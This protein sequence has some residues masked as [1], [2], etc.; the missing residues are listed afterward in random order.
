MDC[1]KIILNN[2][3][4]IDILLDVDK[5]SLDDIAKRVSESPEL[6]DQ[7]IRELPGFNEAFNEDPPKKKSADSSNLNGA[8]NIDN[9]DVSFLLSNAGFESSLLNDN[10]S[11]NLVEGKRDINDNSLGSIYYNSDDNT[12]S[13]NVNT[14]NIDAIDDKPSVLVNDY[15]QDESILNHIASA[16]LA[17]ANP[18]KKKIIGIY[19]NKNEIKDLGEKVNKLFPKEMKPNKSIKKKVEYILSE[20][21]NNDE[22]KDALTKN[23]DSKYIN[24]VRKASGSSNGFEFHVSTKEKEVKESEPDNINESELSFNP[25]EITDIEKKTAI[26]NKVQ[27]FKEWHK[28]M[29]FDSRRDAEKYITNDSRVLSP[30]S[31]IQKKDGTISEALGSSPVL[32]KGE[33]KVS[34]TKYRVLQ[35]FSDGTNKPIT[36]ADITYK[37]MANKNIT[38]DDYFNN[39]LE[40]NVGI[41]FVNRNNNKLT[42]IVANVSKD[43]V[44]IISPIADKTTGK[45][46]YYEI[47]Y[48]K[49][50]INIK[51]IF[52][53]GELYN[54][55][56]N[57]FD[58]VLNSKIDFSVEHKTLSKSKDNIKSISEIT[59]RLQSLTGINMHLINSNEIEGILKD[60]DI[61]AD[62]NGNIRAFAK[63]GEVYIN[64]DNAS[65]AEPLH[66]L[67]HIFLPSVRAVNPRLYN[68]MMEAIQ[69]HPIYNEIS[70]VY[71][72]LKGEDLNMEVFSTVFGEFY[73]KDLIKTEETKTWENENKSLFDK[74]IDMIRNLLNA[75]GIMP[76]VGN[77]KLPYCGLELLMKQFGD[78]VMAGNYSSYNNRNDNVLSSSAAS[79]KRKLMDKGLITK[80][81]R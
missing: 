9:S 76:S 6:L 41:N 35:K 53:K 26:Y 45:H 5:I 4:S 16:L 70:R 43:I 77:E 58:E 63:D 66:E 67:A 42:G 23:L 40:K 14:E 18:N 29:E 22:F 8:Y 61:P 15:Y 62:S 52:A 36:K 78:E 27:W 55:V 11:I 20:F 34:K 51:S 47:T 54:T 21:A 24:A 60:V 32:K 19:L 46:K 17:Q 75:V 79:I 13:I 50:D 30:F 56:K 65:M 39:I 28:V 68:S 38:R 1:K 10:V 71:S 3:A 25:K 37:M 2:N 33:K 44:T 57:K 74:F 80:Y 73:R 31:K 81:C 72:N 12:Y 64:I 48:N 49:G 69:S 7:M 59:T